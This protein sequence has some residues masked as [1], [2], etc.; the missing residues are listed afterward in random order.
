M[1]TTAKRIR[2]RVGVRVM[3]RGLMGFEFGLGLDLEL[4]SSLVGLRL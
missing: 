1:R 3:L 2:F 4:C